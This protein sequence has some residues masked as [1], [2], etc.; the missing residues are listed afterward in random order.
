MG[1]LITK[2]G[3]RHDTIYP[4]LQAIIMRL[5]YSQCFAVTGKL[6]PN[7]Q[8]QSSDGIHFCPCSGAVRLFTDCYP[9]KII[10]ICRYKGSVCQFTAKRLFELPFTALYSVLSAFICSVIPC[11]VKRSAQ[12]IF[13]PKNRKELSYD[14]AKVQ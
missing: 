8:S 4:K 1:Y 3:E 6:R 13:M 5:G 2:G 10:P 9:Y 7:G 12:G 11:A 14:I